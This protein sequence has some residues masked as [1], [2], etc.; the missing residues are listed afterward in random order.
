MMNHNPRSVF[1]A[2]FADDHDDPRWVATRIGAAA[3]RIIDDSKPI[4]FSPQEDGIAI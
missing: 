2:Q 4:A 1:A 3:S